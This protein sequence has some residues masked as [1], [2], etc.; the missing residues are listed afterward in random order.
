MHPANG[1]L[2]WKIFYVALAYCISKLVFQFASSSFWCFLPDGHNA[3]GGLFRILYLPFYQLL[4]SFF[5]QP[6]AYP[7]SAAGNL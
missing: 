6:P 3:A 1:M 4:P 7:F 5:Q 2:I